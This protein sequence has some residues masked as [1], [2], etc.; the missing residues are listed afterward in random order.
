MIALSFLV[1]TNDDV[2]IEPDIVLFMGAPAHGPTAPAWEC[3][4]DLN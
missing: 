4:S 3:E 2:C 1:P